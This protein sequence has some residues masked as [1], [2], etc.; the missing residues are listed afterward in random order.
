MHALS[1]SFLRISISRGTLAGQ[2]FGFLWFHS[3]SMSSLRVQK[4]ISRNY[5][6][7]KRSIVVE[8]IWYDKM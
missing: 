7:A 1:L 6:S 2:L 8:G 3:C 5:P 4:L